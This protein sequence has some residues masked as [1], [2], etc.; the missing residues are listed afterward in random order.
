MEKVRQERLELCEKGLKGEYRLPVK[1]I[2][3][4]L[5]D[6]CNLSCIMCPYK[7]GHNKG[8][9]MSLDD[10][11]TVFMNKRSYDYFQENSF[12]FDATCFGEPLL[13]PEIYEILKFIKLLFLL[14]HIQAFVVMELYPPAVIYQNI[15]IPSAFR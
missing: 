7:T 10:I 8:I 3:F 15:L 4:P 13:H 5:T 12:T 6:K 14:L 1:W 2:N 9:S 11:R